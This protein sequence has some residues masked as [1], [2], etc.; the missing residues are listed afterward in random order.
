MLNKRTRRLLLA[1]V[2]V[3]AISF[4]SIV[5][6]P[7]RAQLDVKDPI[8]SPSA[9][10][11]KLN[12]P[13][14][15]QESNGTVLIL[16]TSYDEEQTYPALILLPWTGG[17]PADYFRD[18]FAEQYR[19]P[20]ESSFILILLN[21]Q[22]SP[23]DYTPPDNFGPTVERY[24]NLVRSHLETLI[25]KYNIDASRVA[26]GGYSLGGDLSWALSLRNPDLFR[27]IVIIGSRSTY[28]AASNMSQLAA[29]DS[30]F[31]MVMGEEDERLRQM[32]E[33]VEELARYD[34]TY[35]FE[36]LPGGEDH[37]SL[38]I[39]QGGVI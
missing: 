25:P 12:E 37:N 22:G 32:R 36:I 31:F 29:N 11:L 27:G 26:T 15:K 24:E 20:V 35:R 2:I 38:F 6:Q 5:M 3:L 1:G 14:R 10:T 28:R 19:E 16:P 8:R 39:P 34:I 7:V 4:V 17:T 33:A 18:T 9:S 23:N 30:R 21:V 13:V